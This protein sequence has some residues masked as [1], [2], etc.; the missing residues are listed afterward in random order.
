MR[1]IFSMFLMLGNGHAISSVSS[2]HHHCHSAQTFQFR[3]HKPSVE[4]RRNLRF[5]VEFW[6]SK[7]CSVFNGCPFTIFVSSLTT[8]TLASTRD[9]HFPMNGSSE[10]S[11]E[12]PDDWTNVNIGKCYKVEHTAAVACFFVFT[13]C[14]PSSSR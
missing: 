9:A 10:P 4:Q 14:I 13:V 12:L 5:Q 11:F 2:K 3:V 6:F 8:Y 7:P 1:N